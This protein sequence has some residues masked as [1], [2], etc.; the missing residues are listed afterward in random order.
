[1]E[2]VEDNNDV[3][4]K[5]IFVENDKRISTNGQQKQQLPSVTFADD[6]NDS[7]VSLQK[8]GGG[9][10]RKNFKRSQHHCVPRERRR[11]LPGLRTRR[12]Q[13]NLQFLLSQIDGIDFD[14]SD[15]VD[16]CDLIDIQPSA[17]T[18]LFQEEEKMAVWNNFVNWTEDE[19]L[20][21]LKVPAFEKKDKN[22]LGGEVTDD[23]FVN[24]GTS[25]EKAFARISQKLRHF[26]NRKQIPKGELEKIEVDLIDYFHEWPNSVY[27]T[28]LPDG[29]KRMLLHAVSQYL[30]LEAKSFDN[31]GNR[32][33]QVEAKNSVFIP[34]ETTLAIIE[35]NPCIWFY[36][37][38]FY[39]VFIA[40]VCTHN[41]KSGVGFSLVKNLLANTDFRV[42]L[43]CRNKK[44]AFAA[45]RELLKTFPSRSVELFFADMS[46]PQSVIRAAQ[47]VK[48]KHSHIDYL[49]FNAGV[50]PNT[51]VDWNY[52]VRNVFSRNCFE[53][54]RTGHNLIKQ[55][56][57]ENDETGLCN[58]F[59]TN[60]FGHI[61]LFK[62]LLS[63]L[64]RHKEQDDNNN[65]N[66]R[67]NNNNKTT[68]V[69][70]TSSSNA[71]R[72]AFN[73]DNIQHKN[74]DEPY[75][76]SKYT[77][78]L[79]SYQMNKNYNKSG[80][81]SHTTCPGLVITNLLY[82]IIGSWF[83]FILLPI[84]SLFRI[85]VSSLTLK[86]DIACY[87]LFWLT[88]QEPRCLDPMSKYYSRCSISGRP[89]VEVI[90][91][92]IDENLAYE[93]TVRIKKMMEQYKILG[94]VA[95]ESNNN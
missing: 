68:H 67:N 73:L 16:L 15:S 61:L 28:C 45:Q 50:M 57:V 65:N 48:L 69:I 92:D 46:N 3:E 35:I 64:G 42:C 94:R 88:K 74:G 17:F 79:L 84:L 87:S 20:E 82:G 9:R 62:E 58:I 11:S 18:E 5:I 30:D 95:D 37:L 52:F 75:S 89:Y 25:A 7:N 29:F 54:I 1:M 34:P 26:L 77:M 12:R 4:S 66:N 47:E 55:Y 91:M 13:E 71:K 44:K 40:A 22:N 36:Y 19:Q 31:L 49:F 86:P 39:Y 76:S 80:I 43:I 81:Y 51:F 23:G 63:V 70:W 6:T 24:L 85:F 38:S 72:S 90:K 8:P 53:M 14:E 59:S 41:T 56:D 78:D 93:A 2:T 33:T 27:V 21:F 32:K 10:K 83:W 60:V